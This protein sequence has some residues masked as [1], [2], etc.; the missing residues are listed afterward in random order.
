[1][2]GQHE[3]K[4]LPGEAALCFFTAQNRTNDPI[5]GVSSYNVTPDVISFPKLF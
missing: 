5:I 3:V 1:M 2:D 4:V